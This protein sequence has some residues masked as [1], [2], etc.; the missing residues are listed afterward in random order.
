MASLADRL[1]R[2]RIFTV[3]RLGAKIK[4]DALPLL[5]T[6]RRLVLDI[7]AQRA[8][9]IETDH[10]V[11][12]S[13]AKATALAAYRTSSKRQRLALWPHLVSPSSSRT[14][15]DAL[16]TSIDATYSRK[17]Q[18]RTRYLRSSNSVRKPPQ[19]CLRTSTVTVGPMPDSGHLGFEYA[20]PQR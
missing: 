15:L 7:D 1:C 14:G 17:E 12:P 4:Q 9:V 6:P 20:T 18:I 13:G 19:N 11:K 16:L 3:P 10:R 5:Y 8:V 2:R